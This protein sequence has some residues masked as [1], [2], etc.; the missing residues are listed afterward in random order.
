[1]VKIN[2]VI[3]LKDFQNQYAESISDPEAFWAKVAGEEIE[4]SQKWVRV[5]EWEYPN[6]R[7]FIGGKLNISHNCL[8]RHI[9]AGLGEKI[10]TFIQTKIIRERLSLIGNC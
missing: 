5:F 3:N 9:K 4:W 6:Y 1:V 8:D 10:A 2:F 7:W